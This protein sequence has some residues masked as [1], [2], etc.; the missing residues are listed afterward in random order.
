MRIKSN[1]SHAKSVLNIDGKP[2]MEDFDKFYTSCA[3][4]GLFHI[5]T[6]SFQHFYYTL[7]LPLRGL[8]LLFPTFSP[9]ISKTDET[10]K[11]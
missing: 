3:V 5:L 4:S 6:G 7:K 2:G 8:C 9:P 10:A 11:Y 1:F